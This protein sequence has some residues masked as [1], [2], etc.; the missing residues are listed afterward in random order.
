MLKLAG[1]LVFCLLPQCL[2]AQ[3]VSGWYVGGALTGGTSD[4]LANWYGRVTNPS[5]Q[6]FTGYNF[7]DGRFVIGPEL[8]IRTHLKEK[9]ILQYTDFPEGTYRLFYKETFSAM[10]SI[11]AGSMI[12]PTF[13]YGKVGMGAA[14]FEEREGGSGREYGKYL[15]TYHQNSFVY[16]VAA[17]AE[18][19]FDRY[20]LRL[21]AEY[22]D[23]PS[24]KYYDNNQ[25]Q[26][27]AGL[28]IRF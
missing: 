5:A 9:E 8:S 18:L 24:Q 25:Y 7:A 11:R 15:S 19:N 28:G 22:R 27:S 21:E 12:G 16:S 20:F 3:D 17:G 10:A 4:H 6:V 13:L 2:L 26:F 23:L 1:S 14:F